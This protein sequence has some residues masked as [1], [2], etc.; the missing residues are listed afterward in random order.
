ME[1]TNHTIMVYKGLDNEA[2]KVIDIDNFIDARRTFCCYVS[3]L[4]DVEPETEYVVV[5]LKNTHVNHGVHIEE[6]RRQNT[7]EIV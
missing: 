1:W 7:L 4:H 6:M 2:R 5:W 3:L